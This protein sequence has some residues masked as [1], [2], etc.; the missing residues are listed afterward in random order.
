MLL[1]QPGI[2]KQQSRNIAFDEIIKD[3]GY[4]FLLLFQHFTYLIKPRNENILVSLCDVFLFYFLD[5]FSLVIKLQHLKGEVVCINSLL[6][7]SH[8][9]ESSYEVCAQ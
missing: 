4:V 3:L 5:D 7:N 9:L 6:C 8:R 2:F 1:L